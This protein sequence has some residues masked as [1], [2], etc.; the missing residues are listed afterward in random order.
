MWLHRSSRKDRIF[1]VRGILPGSAFAFTGLHSKLGPFIQS[2]FPLRTRNQI[3][4]KAFLT[5]STNFLESVF[6]EFVSKIG[7]GDFSR[8]VAL[9]SLFLLVH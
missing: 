2:L 6:R 3:S 8:E 5:L 4:I 7:L 9:Y 1:D